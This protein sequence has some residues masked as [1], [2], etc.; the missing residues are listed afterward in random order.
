MIYI[1]FIDYVLII[2]FYILIT[3]VR[4]HDSTHACC[5]DYELETN[6]IPD[7]YPMSECDL[8]KLME[9][10]GGTLM[11]VVLMLYCVDKNCE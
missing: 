9:V 1:Q 2:F 5:G 10:Y 4:M 6:T 11:V 8:F 3:L 7:Y